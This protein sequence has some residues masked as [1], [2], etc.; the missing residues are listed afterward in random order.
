[1]WTVARLPLFWTLEL[2]RSIGVLVRFDHVASVIVNAKQQQR[3][4]AKIS[5]TRSRSI[6]WE[7]NEGATGMGTESG[8]LESEGV[9][10]AAASQMNRC[11]RDR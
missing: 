1:M 6:L 9:A 5:G 3:G 8:V 11:Q 4:L 2:G 7:G 10:A